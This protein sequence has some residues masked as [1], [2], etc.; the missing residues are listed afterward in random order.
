MKTDF[1]DCKKSV[2]SSYQKPAPVWLVAV[3]ELKSTMLVFMEDYLGQ[4][5]QVDLLD[6]IKVQHNQLVILVYRQNQHEYLIDEEQLISVLL[7][8]IKSTIVI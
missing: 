6:N 5:Y 2:R 7:T 1:I 3:N 8:R 4:T